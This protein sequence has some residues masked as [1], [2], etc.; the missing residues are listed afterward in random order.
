MGWVGGVRRKGER[1]RGKG[2]NNVRSKR[3]TTRLHHSGVIV[4]YSLLALVCCLRLL[5]HEC[6]LAWIFVLFHRRG[7]VPRVMQ[8]QNFIWSVYDSVG[9]GLRHCRHPNNKKHSCFR[10]LSLMTMLFG[11]LDLC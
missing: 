10:S 9:K 3:C 1:G 6:M 5:V 2:E 11:F 4:I 8:H 7:L